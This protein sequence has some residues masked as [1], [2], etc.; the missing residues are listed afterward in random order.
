MRRKRV[1]KP[2]WGAI[3]TLWLVLVQSAG[4]AHAVSHFSNPISANGLAQGD[5]E[6]N[7]DGHASGW[8]CDQCHAFSGLDHSPTSTVR[9]GLDD[10]IAPAAVA[11]YTPPRTAAYLLSPRSR[12]PPAFL[13]GVLL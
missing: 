9:L 1:R 5:G 13:L 8:Y 3:L 2:V 7:T 12:A 6:R 4:L 11:R 10:A